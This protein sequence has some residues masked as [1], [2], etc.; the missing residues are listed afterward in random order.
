MA[1]VDIFRSLCPWTAGCLTASGSRP[2]A[3]HGLRWLLVSGEGGFQLGYGAA[4][5]RRIEG[6]GAAV[7][8]GGFADE[9]ESE[10]GAFAAGAGV[11]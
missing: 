4:F 7:K 1:L 2:R 11:A 10:A 6:D 5:V 8:F 9:G 3:V